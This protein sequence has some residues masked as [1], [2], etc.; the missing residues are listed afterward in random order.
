MNHRLLILILL[1]SFVCAGY[2]QTQTQ[3][4]TA[5]SEPQAP[6][7][8]IVADMWPPMTGDTLD[9]GGF[10]VQLT[11]EILHELGF[12]TQVRF[13]PWKRIIRTSQRGSFDVVPAI[14]EDKKREDK[15]EL[16]Q[17]YLNYN[18]MFVSLKSKAFRFS[19]LDDLTGQRIG[20][21]SSYA[22]PEALLNYKQAQW[23]TGIDIKQNLKK[24]LANR[25]DL[26]LG[27]QEVIRY[28]AHLLKGEDQLF[29]DVQHP[30]ENR[31]LHIGINRQLP[32]HQALIRDIDRMMLV[33]KRNGRFDQLKKQH[34]LL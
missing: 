1:M 12:R 6:V 28:E 34:G 3:A 7:L 26:V 30:V 25:L 24:L 19:R 21:V 27:T 33:F 31:A 13:V 5:I 23:K 9:H 4:S 20:I 17:P 22:Y 16:S 18:L 10:S 15:F 8:R 14:W 29:Y 11:Q 2:A 32:N